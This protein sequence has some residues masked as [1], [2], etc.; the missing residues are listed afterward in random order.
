MIGPV[1]ELGVRANDRYMY[2]KIEEGSR[3]AEIHELDIKKQEGTSLI[4]HCCTGKYSL[5]KMRRN[6]LS[7]ER[8]SRG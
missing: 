2:L 4:N 8:K 5:N 1:K 3:L 7:Y 6:S